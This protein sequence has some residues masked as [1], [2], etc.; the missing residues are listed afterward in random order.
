MKTALPR[1]MTRRHFMSH[2]AGASA[3]AIPALSMGHT[4]RTHA[5]DLQARRKSAI[6]LWMSGGPSSMDIWDLKPGA[7]TGGPFQQIPTSGNAQI[8]EHM[9]LM[10]K[11]MHHMAIVRSMSTR[12]ADHSRGRQRVVLLVSQ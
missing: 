7:P 4:L 1:G 6:L 12:E 8:C 9:P 10:A 2:V 5:H 11:Q 3:M